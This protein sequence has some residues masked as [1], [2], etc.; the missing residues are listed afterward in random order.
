MAFFLYGA[1]FTSNAQNP[2]VSFL[3]LARKGKM[4]ELFK[5]DVGDKAFFVAPVLFDSYPE[6]QID[7]TA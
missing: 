5:A 2:S 3:P 6:L 4:T 7:L 1:M